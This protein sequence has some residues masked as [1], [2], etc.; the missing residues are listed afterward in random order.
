MGFEALNPLD[1]TEPQSVP[2]S[3]GQTTTFERPYPPGW[4]DRLTDW[5]DRMPGPN[6][7]YCLGLLLFQFGYATA[8]L[9]L[10]RRLPVGSIDFGRLFTVVVAPYLIW[11]RFYLDRVAAA[12][13]DVFRPMLAVNDAEFLRL[14]YELTTL[15][16]RTARIVTLVTVPVF[17]VN[18]LLLPDSEARQ[19]GSSSEAALIVMGPIWLFA[20][21]VV[22][23]SMAQAI[24]QLRMVERIYDRVGTIH[25]LRAK[26]LHA[27]SQLTARIGMSFLL[28]AYYVAAVRPDA[29][30]NSPAL[31]ALLVAMVPT[32]LA[33]FV[34]PLRGMHRRLAAEKD[35]ALTQV[36]SRLEAVFMRLHERVDQE[37]LADA[38]KLNHQITSLSAERE[39]LARVSTWPWE[40]AT[41][42][43]FLTTLVLP[44]LLWG[45]QHVLARVGF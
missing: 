43:G 17:F 31:E 33:C 10:T 15:P 42:T 28:L 20:V 44:A 3:A 41:L 36:A 24:H 14:R 40:L 23:V 6:F 8:L 29:V 16:A 22:T 19:Y 25:L 34:L 26:P 1:V 18:S 39:A 38:D 13:M 11:T 27:F 2:R 12:G 7:L 30:S 4:L 37:V 21:A 32:A 5:V 45:I 9:W 35:R